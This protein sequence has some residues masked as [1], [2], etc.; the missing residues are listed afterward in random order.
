MW[1]GDGRT[2]RKGTDRENT[3]WVAC[4][5]QL[6]VGI[7]DYVEWEEYYVASWTERDEPFKLAI[8]LYKSAGNSINNKLDCMNN[9]SS[10][11]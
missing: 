8:R 2:W 4:S 6:Y 11:R 10:S 7:E 9:K 3:D 1:E 5:G